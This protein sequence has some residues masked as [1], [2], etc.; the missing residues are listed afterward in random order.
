VTL[1]W[2]GSVCPSLVAVLLP[3]MAS[4]LLL[5][6]EGSDT[7]PPVFQSEGMLEASTYEYYEYLSIYFKF[8][9]QEM[10]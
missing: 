7:V 10:K 3:N 9:N 6:P 5:I 2:F 1:N 4:S 8:L